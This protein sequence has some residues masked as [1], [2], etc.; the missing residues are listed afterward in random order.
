[1]G[2]Y[3][4]NL[5]IYFPCQLKGRKPL[6]WFHEKWNRCRDRQVRDLHMRKAP[7][8]DLMDLKCYRDETEIN[9][10]SIQ[11][12][13]DVWENANP[14]TAPYALHCLQQAYRK[15]REDN[16]LSKN[17][18]VVISRFTLIYEKSHCAIPY[19]I[20]QVEGS[21]IYNVNADNNIAT[22]I[23]MLHFDKMFVDDIILLKHIFYKRLE[24]KIQEYKI[25]YSSCSCNAVHNGVFS[26]V[27]GIKKAVIEP[28]VSFQD[29]IAQK[30]V[31]LRF[32]KR[33]DV[34][35]RARYSFVE[36]D[37]H[38]FSKSLYKDYYGIMF[39]DEGYAYLSN[40]RQNEV[41]RHNLSIRES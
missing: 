25:D 10:R 26:C 8:T 19:N 1:M 23:V 22:Y 39:A 14:E 11:S 31:F 15:N 28:Y 32:A 5:S 13:I 30:D 27:T 36:L 38:Y 3:S 2:L 4:G 21:L 33:G 20:I 37:N 29:Y 9:L 40:R 41:F 7:L 12:R 18:S 16:W 35:Y 34:D 6:K 24:V 17:T